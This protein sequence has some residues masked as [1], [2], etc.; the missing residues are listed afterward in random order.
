MSTEDWSAAESVEYWQSNRAWILSVRSSRGGALW[1]APR[2]ARCS[3]ILHP[4]S[5]AKE[6]DSFGKI[7]SAFFTTSLL[8]YELHCARISCHELA[9]SWQSPSRAEIFE[10]SSASSG[11]IWKT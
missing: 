6:G 11:E 2:A 7:R 9:T 5:V 1:A 8:Y 10:E 3:P 4:R